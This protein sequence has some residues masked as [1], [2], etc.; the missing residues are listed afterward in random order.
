ME[1]I[2]S[3]IE[4]D[5]IGPRVESGCLKE[6]TGPSRGTGRGSEGQ[7]QMGENLAKHRG[8]FDGGDDRQGAAAVRSRALFVPVPSSDRRS[9]SISSLFLRN[10]IP[11]LL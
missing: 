5:G 10:L 7:S 2:G 6:V 9:S 4:P 11:I 3:G 1:V 8:I